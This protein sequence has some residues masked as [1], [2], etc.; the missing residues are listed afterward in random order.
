MSERERDLLA[1]RVEV[2]KALEIERG[3]KRKI[4]E[5][6]MQRAALIDTEEGFIRRTLETVAEAYQVSIE[7]VRGVSR[8]H[9][10]IEPRWVVCWCLRERGLS[11]PDI[12]KVMNRHHSSILHGLRQI[13]LNPAVLTIAQQTYSRQVA[14]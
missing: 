8:E 11:L 3:L 12:A 5:L 1:L 14:A 10:L 4:H 2:D 9:F 7:D 13:K 6:N